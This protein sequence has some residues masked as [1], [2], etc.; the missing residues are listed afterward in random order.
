VIDPIATID[1]A[2]LRCEALIEQL[3]EIADT[4]APAVAIKAIRAQIRAAE[5]EMA[6]LQ[7]AGYCR[8]RCRASPTTWTRTERLPEPCRCS[9]ATVCP[10]K[11]RPS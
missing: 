5:S 4:A 3:A 1:A 8:L 2:V 10:P 11:Q 6:L 7:N 9:T